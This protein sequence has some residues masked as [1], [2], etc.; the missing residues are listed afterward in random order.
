MRDE[1]LDF[2]RAKG[3]NAFFM[4]S[5]GV[6]KTMMVLDFMSRHGL[7]L[8][9]NVSQWSTPLLDFVGCK[10]E[11]A[12]V[13]F[14]D[15][16]NDEKSYQAA[17]E[18]IA[19]RRWKGKAIK[20]NAVVW[21]CHTT[22]WDAKAKAY[23]YPPDAHQ[24]FEVVVSIPCSIN[25][26]YFTAKFGRRVADSAFEWWNDLPFR[27]ANTEEVLVSPRR[28]E[29]A[30]DMWLV[31]GDM[32]DVL[33]LECPVRTLMT[34]LNSG[35]VAD[36]LHELLAQGDEAK[37]L[38]LADDN[39][40]SMALGYICKSDTLLRAFLPLFGERLLPSL[41]DSEFGDKI[42]TY[43][44]K[45]AENVPYFKEVLQKVI[46]D[47]NSTRLVKKIRRKLTEFQDNQRSDP[48]ATGVSETG[49]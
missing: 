6:G 12:D 3:K 46:R 27:Y 38:F 34:K 47:N 18:V 49:Q 19:L 14:F 24:V 40:F 17:K 20:P 30:L 5:T 26:P 32:R 7:S 16:C 31:K 25:L 28:L 15:D 22:V 39:N 36:K 9:T 37:K 23:T 43:A 11:D 13:L 45:E 4:G 33:P 35:P 41:S 10:P 44:V 48:F 2:W 42:L 8:D 1:K 21:A 29:Q